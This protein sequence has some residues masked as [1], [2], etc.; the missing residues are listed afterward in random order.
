M[1]SLKMGSKS[2]KYVHRNFIEEWWIWTLKQEEFYTENIWHGDYFLAPFE[3]WPWMTK[4]LRFKDVNWGS[5]MFVNHLNKI[6]NLR[7]LLLCEWRL[8]NINLSDLLVKRQRM[9]LKFRC[10]SWSLKYSWSHMVEGKAV[11]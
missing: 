4:N 5:T 9:V 10:Q 6:P 1:D 2:E 8:C 7:N 11:T 3:I